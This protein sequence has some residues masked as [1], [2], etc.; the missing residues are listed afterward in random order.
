M[1]FI[2]YNENSLSVNIKQF[3]EIGSFLD[4]EIKDSEVW[5]IAR[6]YEEIPYFTN[7]YQSL[8]LSRIV[9]T[10][11]NIYS[12]EMDCFINGRDTHLY[13][14]KNNQWTAISSL[15]ELQ[16]LIN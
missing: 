14:R 11:K 4:V 6:E 16:E 10:A 13:N 8:L 15:E 5:E 9:E 2:N 7:I 3:E 1:A 12:L